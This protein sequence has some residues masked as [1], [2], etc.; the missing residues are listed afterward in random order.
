MSKSRRQV[1]QAAAL[2]PAG[3]LLA[4]CAGV[5]VADVV[6]DLENAPAALSAALTSVTTADPSA[7]PAATAGSI[8][9]DLALAQGI[10]SALPSNLTTAS[11]ATNAQTIVAYINSGIALLADPPVSGLIPAPF[12][13][14]IA[15]FD[16][17]L[18]GIESAAAALL[19][20]AAAA[21]AP[22]QGISKAEAIRMRARL[23]NPGM[24]TV[25]QARARLVALA[26]HL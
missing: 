17:V 21:A 20:A 9:S 24:A 18:P 14:A 19:P 2:I 12:N 1:L 26:R 8:Q 15:A 6:S 23:E 16:L 10:A 7:I 25:A 5:T 11:D 4:K 22:H 3:L 13:E